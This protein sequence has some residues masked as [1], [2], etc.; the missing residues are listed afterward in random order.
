MRAWQRWFASAVLGLVG[1]AGPPPP[2]GSQSQGVVSLPVEQDGWAHTFGEATA[3]CSSQGLLDNPIVLS[4]NTGVPTGGG[5]GAQLQTGALFFGCECCA[6]NG[7]QKDFFVGPI[8][9]DGWALTGWFH[10]AR[11][12]DPFTV[13]SMRI[14]LLANGN[15]VGH[16]TYAAEQRANNN[17]RPVNES[18]RVLSNGGTFVIKLSTIAAGTQL[19]TIRVVLQGYACQQANQFGCAN[20]NVTNE[21]DVADFQLVQPQGCQLDGDCQSGHCVDGACCDSACANLPNAASTCAGGVCAIT[22]CSA[23]HGDCDGDVGDGCEAD[24]GGDPHNCGGCGGDCGG[25]SCLHGACCPVNCSFPHT[26]TTCGGGVCQ[27]VGCDAAWAD[28]DGNPLNGCEVNLTCAFT[29]GCGG[30][31]FVD[32]DGD[33]LSDAWETLGVD[34]DCDGTIDLALGA[35]PYNADRLHKDVYVQE[36]WM[37]LAQAQ[38]D[39]APHSDK[40]PQFEIDDTVA[41]FAAAPLAN[42][43]GKDGVTLHFFEGQAVPH[44][45][46]ISFGDGKQVCNFDYANF[47]A[48]KAQSFDPRRAPV[49]HYLIAAH[50]HDCFDVGGQGE[51]AGNDFT[52]F[53]SHP[54]AAFMHELGHNLG[55]DHGG[56]DPINCKPNYRSVMNYGFTGGVT[57]TAN[58]G[59]RF[60]T[61]STL[62]Y[63]RS[64]LPPLDEFNLDES[65]GV[66]GDPHEVTHHAC[67]L[68]FGFP[69]TGGTCGD[70]WQWDNGGA[71]IDWDCDGD[72][73]DSHLTV[74]TTGDGVVEGALVDQ[75][76]WHRLTYRYQCFPTYANGPPPPEF[77]E[78]G[79]PTIDE[80]RASH[81]LVPPRFVRIDVRPGCAGNAVAPSS[82]ATVTIAVFSTVD[83]DATELDPASLIAQSARASATRVADVD[84]DGLPDLE[85]DFPMSAMHLS[86]T[87]TRVSFQGALPSSQAVFGDDAVVVVPK[88]VD[89]KD[90][91]PITHPPTAKCQDVTV[92]ADAQCRATASIDGGSFDP[93]AVG[94]AITQDP[95]N[96]LAGAGPHPVTLTVDNGVFAATCS[97]TVT[98]VD[99]TPPSLAVSVTP[100]QLWPPDHKLVKIAPTLAAADGCDAHPSLSLASVT[101][102]EPPAPGDIVAI[103]IDDIQLAASRAG[104]GPG[105]TYTLTF[106]ATDAA[107]NH[108]D[109]AATVVVP[110]DR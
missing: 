20:G 11:S 76:D 51:I 71:A 99:V 58:P 15:E 19:D 14:D 57:T 41:A 98:V 59:D 109:A 102:S 78:H 101:S 72:Y 39:E 32:S 6:C 55:L 81:L 97:A 73:G 27:V 100:G 22:S 1:C 79:D 37:E 16:A 105:R 46:F 66:Q 103:G 74:D 95:P 65:V 62:D 63:S 88:I 9:S 33:G 87:G 43:D 56:G 108:A 28:C 24:L 67:P 26:Q 48:L 68:P 25:G 64:A 36:D 96:P 52:V 53:Q 30:G 60:Y 85:A 82:D 5:N 75:D 93:D 7:Y 31:C 40:L 34:T 92:N 86:A 90:G 18:D 47:Y 12:D 77:I 2:P 83:F 110:H 38:G 17:C 54:Y 21:I 44:H 94:L 4:F 84:H 3:S 106:R 8:N 45:D 80:L 42:P 91:C 61:T 69:A 13:A 70:I 49:F 29:N 35:P 10:A 89:G 107:G 23:G 50:R 104:N